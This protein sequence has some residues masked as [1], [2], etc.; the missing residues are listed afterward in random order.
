MGGGCKPFWPGV[1]E[2]LMEEF[3]ELCQKGLKVKHYWFRTQ[4]HQVM[5]ELYPGAEFQFSPGWFHE[6]KVRNKISYH[7]ATN[8]AQQKPVDHEEKICMFHLEIRQ[9]AGSEATDEPLDKF[10][11]STVSNVD[12]TPLPFT[13]SK[14]QEYNQTGTKTVWYC[15]AQSGLDKRQYT[16]QL[17]IFTD[18]EPRIKPLLIFRGEGLRIS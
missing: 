14:G 12:H 2:K 3:K 18:G 7:R 9:G 17:T 8:G 16:V 4:S 6:F 10:N 1:E 13:F 11:L 15:G 5:C